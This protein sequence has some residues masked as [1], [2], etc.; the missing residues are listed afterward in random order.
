MSNVAE[1]REEPTPT[2]IQT[3]K[4]SEKESVQQRIDGVRN[5]LQVFA[6]MHGWKQSKNNPGIW[7]HERKNDKGLDVINFVPS[8]E[9][10]GTHH[11]G[12]AYVSHDNEAI[13]D[14]EMFDEHI[15]DYITKALDEA[16]LA[17]IKVPLPGVLP[18]RGRPQAQPHAGAQPKAPVKPEAAEEKHDAEITPKPTP[19]PLQQKVSSNLPPSIESRK[20]EQ[21]ARVKAQVA[22]TN[23]KYDARAGAQSHNAGVAPAP[24]AEPVIAAADANV[25]TPKPK[26]MSVSSEQKAVG[27]DGA[28]VLVVTVSDGAV[29]ITLLRPGDS[30]EVRR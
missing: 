25:A 2:P 3:E 20:N 8:T 26:E 15:N 12:R 11:L 16:T 4:G 19:Q 7:T 27:N 29:K 9:Y 23:A 10:P 1:K 28:S 14:R 21:N 24:A 5:R 13:Y 17:D 22:E 6:K 18:E 30:V